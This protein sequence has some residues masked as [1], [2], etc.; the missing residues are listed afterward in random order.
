MGVGGLGE[1][2]EPKKSFSLGT[3]I[4][5]VWVWTLDSLKCVVCV[6]GGGGGG[7]GEAHFLYFS[8]ILSFI[9]FAYTPLKWK[10][11]VLN[12]YRDRVNCFEKPREPPFSTFFYLELGPAGPRGP[13]PSI[14]SGPMEP[15]V[16]WLVQ[17]KN[18]SATMYF[19]TLP[20]L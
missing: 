16:S 10:L 3:Q 4:L 15:K 14:L 5:R 13:Q 17:P 1:I 2:E 20:I 8:S 19:S 6:C 7:V 9:T 11:K 18:Y 12:K